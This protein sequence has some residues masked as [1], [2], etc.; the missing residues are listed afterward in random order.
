MSGRS[1]SDA[2]RMHGCAQS[3]RKGVRTRCRSAGDLIARFATFFAYEYV[4]RTL[5]QI[6]AGPNCDFITLFDPVRRT[7][8]RPSIISSRENQLG[9]PHPEIEA[10]Q[11]ST[12]IFILWGKALVHSRPLDPRRIHST[13]SRHDKFMPAFEV[14]ATNS[15]SV[16]F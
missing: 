11:W 15:V 3:Q 12:Y 13:F 16:A 4:F 6:K 8:P 1:A 2:F 10:G 14:S 7:E 5:M 9:I